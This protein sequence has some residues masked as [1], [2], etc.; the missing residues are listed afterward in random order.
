MTCACASSAI[1]PAN[2][3]SCVQIA[4]HTH[5]NSS[6]RCAGVVAAVTL[7]RSAFPNRLENTVVRFKYWQLWDREAYPSKGTSDMDKAVKLK[8]DCEAL[9]ECC[10]KPL[11]EKVQDLEINLYGNNSLSGN[12]REYL[13]AEIQVA[14]NQVLDSGQFILGPEILFIPCMP[15]Y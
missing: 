3:D 4:A 9:L 14:I 10:L 5:T 11:E 7:S 12:Q 13:K 6:L 8:H 2:R 1:R 15:P